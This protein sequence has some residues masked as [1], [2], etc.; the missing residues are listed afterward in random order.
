MLSV[1]WWEEKQDPSGLGRDEAEGSRI[2]ECKLDCLNLWS[3]SHSA[4]ENPRIKEDKVQ[5]RNPLKFEI[6]KDTVMLT[7]LSEASVL[8]ILK[9]RLCSLPTQGKFIKMHFCARG[10]LSSADI[11][12]YL[13]EKY[14]VIFQQ[15]R[16][17][18]CHIFYQILSGRKE[19]HGMWCSSSLLCFPQC[20]SNCWA[21]L[22]GSK[23]FLLSVTL[24]LGLCP[25]EIR[26]YLKSI[27]CSYCSE[28]ASQPWGLSLYSIQA[29]GLELSPGPDTKPS[30]QSLTG[31]LDITG[32]EILDLITLLKYNSLEQ[33]CINLN[34]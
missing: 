7:H 15:P 9:R 26:S 33:L 32:F 31:I 11:D 22:D 25:A 29:Q 18:C 1:E 10:K 12:I 13:L 34:Q 28:F 30:R 21:C 2:R 5:H 19:L 23:T 6:T 8:H 27:T 20:L 24:E 16:E 14:W 3:E 4:F 17:S